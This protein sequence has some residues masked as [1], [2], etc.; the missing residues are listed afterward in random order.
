MKYVPDIW[1]TYMESL[2]TGNIELYPLKICDSES[3]VSEVPVMQGL[4][5]LNFTTKLMKSLFYALESVS[6]SFIYRK[7]LFTW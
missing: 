1:H 4:C 7:F 5:V 3:C 2:S 6:L